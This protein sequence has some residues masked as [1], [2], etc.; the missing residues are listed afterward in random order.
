MDPLREEEK[1]EKEK[2]EKNIKK[3][4]YES[5]GRNKYTL[6]K[7]GHEMELIF[8]RLIKNTIKCL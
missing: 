5:S 7:R 6:E 3:E 1:K 4:K 8:S 2:E